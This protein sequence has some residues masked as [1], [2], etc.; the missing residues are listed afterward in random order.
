MRTIPLTRGK[1]AIVD[2]EDY[3]FLMQ[4]KWFCD[5]N[6]YAAKGNPR[7]L[8]HRVVN[9]TPIGMDTDHIN[10]DRL[11]NRRCNLRS[12]TRAQNAVNRPKQVNNTSGF[13]GVTWHKR[14]GKW[15][16]WIIESKKQSHL[17][18]FDSKHQAAAIVDKEAIKRTGEFA[19]LNLACSAICA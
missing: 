7:I 4:Y 9:D 10:G 5:S 13:K 8:M 16:A 12:A 18:Y 14:I 2:D 15:Q 3:D 19:R 17:G 1:F 6:D 11:D